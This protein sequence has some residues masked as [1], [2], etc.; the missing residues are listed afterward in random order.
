MDLRGE[1]RRG[2]NFFFYPYCSFNESDIGCRGKM[3]RKKPRK[4]PG[5]T[6]SQSQA[7]QR[8]SRLTMALNSCGQGRRPKATISVTPRVYDPGWRIYRALPGQAFVFE[9]ESVDAWERL[10]IGL[11]GKL[12]EWLGGGDAG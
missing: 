1:E 10:W 9:I 11:E 3:K 2:E 8:K 6:L 7:R 12:R 5:E 4:M